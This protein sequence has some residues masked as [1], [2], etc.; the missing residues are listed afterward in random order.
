MTTTARMLAISMTLGAALCPAAENLLTFG[1]PDNIEI[2][3]GHVSFGA[4]TPRVKT[5][6]A[7][8]GFPIRGLAPGADGVT[9]VYG[10]KRGETNSRQ[11]WRAETRDAM[12]FTN[13]RMLFEL[14][15]TR[16]RW[17]VGDVV[18]RDGTLFLL[19]S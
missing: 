2:E 17:L 8:P 15:A 11:V 10:L 19:Q 14:P 4:E 1:F 16:P 18:L 7:G 3:Y 9:I 13:E 5:D 6:V 12:T